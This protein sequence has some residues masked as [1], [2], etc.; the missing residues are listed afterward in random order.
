MSIFCIFQH[1]HIERRLLTLKRAAIELTQ[2]SVSISGNMVRINFGKRVFRTKN[3]MSKNT[4][5]KGKRKKTKRKRK[6]GETEKRE[7]GKVIPPPDQR[8]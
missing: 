1:S 6:N 8:I 4:E 3:K 5:E 2:Y 7:T